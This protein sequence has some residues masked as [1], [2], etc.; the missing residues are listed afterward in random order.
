VLKN[1]TITVSEEAL[2]WAR[3]R[4][5]EEETSVSRLLGHMLEEK[6]RAADAYRAAHERWKKLGTI[7][8]VTA[9]DRFTRDQVHER[10]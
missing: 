2:R 4:A 3:R 1:V 5:A 9:S 10:R 6:M 7:K 8:D